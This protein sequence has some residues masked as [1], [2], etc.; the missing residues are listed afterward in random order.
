MR[1]G[2]NFRIS[3]LYFISKILI[4]LFK[5]ENFYKEGV[6]LAPKVYGGLTFNNEEILKIKGLHHNAIE[7][8]I[9]YS[10]LKSL[11]NKDSSLILNH[12]KNNINLT[13]C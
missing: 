4:G 10:M 12:T 3:D 5:E 2:F 11:L 8:Q 1:P 6:F 7:T 9:N 13:K